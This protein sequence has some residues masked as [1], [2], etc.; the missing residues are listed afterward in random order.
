MALVY[1][2]W[3]LAPALAR[4]GQGELA[5][6]TMGSAETLWQTRFGGVLDA[7]DRRDLKRLRRSVRLLLGPDAA[8]AAWRRGAQRPL[9]EAV[10]RVLEAPAA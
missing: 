2:L 9:A 10:R 8:A 3:N 6:E 1:A 7:G 5:A 4:L